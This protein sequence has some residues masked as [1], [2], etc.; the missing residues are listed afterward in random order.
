MTEAIARDRANLAINKNDRLASF[1]ET[2]LSFYRRHNEIDPI[3]KALEGQVLESQRI[4]K[5]KV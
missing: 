5:S 3:L 4:L 1:K 2:T